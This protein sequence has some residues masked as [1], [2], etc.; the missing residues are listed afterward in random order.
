MGFKVIMKREYVNN[1]IANAFASGMLIEKH[2]FMC[3]QAHFVA[4]AHCFR[5]ALLLGYGSVKSL[6]C[7]VSDTYSLFTI[8]Y[9]FPK[10]LNAF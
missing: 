9:Y 7:D 1:N 2:R 10:G 5:N 6:A 4:K 3:R 8:T